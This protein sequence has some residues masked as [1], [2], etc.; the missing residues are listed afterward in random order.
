MKKLLY[1]FLLASISFSLFAQDTIYLDR[2]YNKTD[3]AS[4]T[5]IHIVDQ[6]IDSTH[7]PYQDYNED[8]VLL[9]SGYVYSEDLTIRDGVVTN[10]HENG[11]KFSEEF[12]VDG[13]FDEILKQWDEE[14]KQT[15]IV[16]PF[17]HVEIKPEYPGGDAALLK[18][19]AKHI[20]YPEIAKEKGYQG[21]VFLQFV[22]D[23][24]GKVTQVKVARGV[25]EVL[26]K[27]AARVV[28]QLAQWTPGEHKG[29]KVAVSYIVPV[30]FRLD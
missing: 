27:E 7:Y 5:I 30:Y 22:I 25:Q 17:Y 13:E 14:G 21:K 9:E 23:K 12:F 15:L 1:I 19:L 8:F 24:T 4:A 28:S 10:Y 3:R 6:S 26:D 18:F 16:Y 2:S 20:V 11:V 29:K